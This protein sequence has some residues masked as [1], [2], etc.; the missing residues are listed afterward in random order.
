[1]EDRSPDLVVGVDL[2]ATKLAA[3]LVDSSGRVLALTRWPDQVRAYD[4]ALDAVDA[5]VHGLRGQAAEWGRHVAAAGVAAAA[6]FDADREVVV[7]APILDWHDR[8]LRADLAGRLRLPVVAENDANA[9]AWGEYRHGAGI[10]ERCLLM[11]T[12]GTGVGGGVVID[13]R[14]LSGG[15]GLAAE[16]GHVQVGAEGRSCPCGAHDCLEQY[17]SGTALRRAARGAAERDPGASSRLL[18]LAGSDL[19]RI[20]GPLITEAARDGDPLA[21]RVVDD[22]G[23]WLGRGLAQMAAVLDPSLMLVGG[24]LAVADELILEPA[25]RAYAACVGFHGVRPPAP[26]RAAALGNTAGVIGVAALA[27]ARPERGDPSRPRVRTAIRGTGPRRACPLEE[28]VA[29]HGRAGAGGS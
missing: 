9:A 20:D 8:P 16:L 17:A 10:G 26:M 29:D 2:G 3:G 6:L 5:L 7:H 25:R 27:R 24:G 13:D 23:T 1:M 14:L 19:E 12:L 11:V 18:A 4:D 15:F 21:R 22:V 28:E